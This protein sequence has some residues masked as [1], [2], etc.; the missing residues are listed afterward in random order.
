MAGVQGII[1]DINTL[2][3]MILKWSLIR[4]RE[5]FFSSDEM[6]CPKTIHWIIHVTQCV[7]NE[8]FQSFSQI[9]TLALP[10]QLA[11]NGT[12][13]IVSFK[14]LLD[15]TMVIASPQALQAWIFCC[16]L[17]ALLSLCF[18]TMCSS[19]LQLLLFSSWIQI[20]VLETWNHFVAVCSCYIELIWIFDVY[21]CFL[22]WAP[23]AALPLSLG[24]A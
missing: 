22:I 10:M 1:N 17:S 13:F 20:Q 21:L 19:L 14:K 2:F 18:P 8:S 6:L 5:M 11:V 3:L 16:I 23:S 15:R 4:L 12:L 24:T 7:L 9:F